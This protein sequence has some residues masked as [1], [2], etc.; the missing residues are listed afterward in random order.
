MR[1]YKDIFWVDDNAHVCKVKIKIIQ[2]MIQIICLTMWNI[3]MIKD[4]SID[5][6]EIE[7]YGRMIQN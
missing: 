1:E 5:I 2:E 6:A 4:I 7:S 3:K